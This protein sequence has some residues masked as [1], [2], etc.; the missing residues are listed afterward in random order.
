MAYNFCHESSRAR[1]TLDPCRPWHDQLAAL[2]LW[3]QG[4]RSR[5]GHRHGLRDEPEC[6]ATVQRLLV[7]LTVVSDD[8]DAL[9][10]CFALYADLLTSL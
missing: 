1:D 7:P 5:S 4:L 3:L 10:F 6:R 8:V 9:C 2:S